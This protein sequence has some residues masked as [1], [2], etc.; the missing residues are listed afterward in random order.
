MCGSGVAL[1][2]SKTIAFM[3]FISSA[4]SFLKVRCKFVPSVTYNCSRSSD[5][6]AKHS[7]SILNRT[8]QNK[9]NNEDVI[10]I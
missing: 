3:T 8:E 4:S 1:I 10:S 6:V 7:S 9:Y 5:V 2:S